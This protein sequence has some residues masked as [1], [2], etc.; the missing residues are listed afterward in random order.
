MAR[1]ASE[2]IACIA[3]A[4]DSDP[5]L[6]AEVPL[7]DGLAWRHAPV[8]FRR[9]CLRVLPRSHR[10]RPAARSTRSDTAQG[11]PGGT[12]P[13]LSPF[14]WTCLPPAVRELP[15]LRTR[16]RERARLPSR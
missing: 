10:A 8:P 5:R 9:A 15:R 13:G 1:A 11:L 2:R 4:A 3:V 14:R 16:A 7:I 12:R 6:A